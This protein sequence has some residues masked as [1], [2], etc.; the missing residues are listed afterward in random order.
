MG[1]IPVL[2][3]YD[4]P[5]IQGEGPLIGKKVLF[6]RTAGCDYRCSWCVVEGS[7][8]MLFDG[9]SKAIEDIAVLD[10]IIGFDDRQWLLRPT[11][12]DNVLVREHLECYE[13]TT[14]ERTVV[15]T[16][17]HRWWTLAGW[18]ATRDLD[19]NELVAVVVSPED[20]V[21]S[22]ETLQEVPK[23]VGSRVVYD[24]TCSPYASFVVNGFV[25]HNCDSAF[26]WDGSE[27]GNTRLMSAGELWEECAKV[28]DSQG[29]LNYNMITISGGNPAL[30]GSEMRGFLSY[31][32]NAGVET[33]LETQ[34]SKI[35]S[36]FGWVDHLV[37]S[38][39]PPSSLQATNY[40]VLDRLINTYF[41]PAFMGV[42]L[43]VVVFD[44]RDFEYARDLH[45]RY[46]DVPMYL[47]VGNEHVGSGE[48]FRLALLD[49]LSWLSNKVLED[50]ELNDVITLPQLHTLMW[51]NERGV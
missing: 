46:P 45:K 51:G 23:F 36:W 34:G 24:L 21:C 44:D 19:E 41:D 12:V 3:V 50:A 13:I 1:K 11:Q 32:S 29:R 20:A 25:G 47:Q 5:T 10:E 22:W 26:T 4:R 17:D 31:C 6:V 35:Q 33:S 18:K 49:K 7:Q 28:V 27:K 15:A 8:V 38:P 14:G 30:V 9:S 40:E 43:K 2:E 48:D 37:V 16:G 39:K 42:Y